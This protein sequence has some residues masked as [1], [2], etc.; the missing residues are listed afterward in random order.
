MVCVPT[1]LAN[2]FA[3]EAE[4]LAERACKAAATG[5]MQIL[6]VL[7]Y[8]TFGLSRLYIFPVK[9][10]SAVLFGYNRR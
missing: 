2:M 1:V 6:F 8:I 4:T 10:I 5:R 9:V 3:I 7:N